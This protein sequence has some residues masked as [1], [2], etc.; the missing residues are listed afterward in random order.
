MLIAGEEVDVVEVRRYITYLLYTWH[1]SLVV[2]I[3]IHKG[4]AMEDLIQEVL[5]GLIQYPGT[6]N[7][8][9]W[10][11]YVKNMVKWTVIEEARNIWCGARVPSS[12]WQGEVGVDEI[13]FIE[14]RL[15]GRGRDL[16][17]KLLV[18]EKAI[19]I[20]REWGVSK[21]RVSQ[22]VNAALEKLCSKELKSTVAGCGKKE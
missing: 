16:I 13:D 10:T 11:T 2:R 22:L 1:K 15:K 8:A 21:Q 19:D 12:E 17:L 4:W 6:G 9:K 14:S 5:T 3:K 7:G 20:A 18:G